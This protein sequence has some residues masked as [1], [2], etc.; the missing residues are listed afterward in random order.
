MKSQLTAIRFHYTDVRFSFS[1][2]TAAKENIVQL[3]Q[4]E[5]KSIEHINYIFCSDAYLLELNKGYLK[6]NTLTDIIT[7]H[8]HAE[9]APVHSD[10]YIS[11]ERVKE[12]A[13]SFGVSFRHELHRV[14]FHGALHLCG[15]KDKTKK[16]I[17]QMRAKEEHYLSLFHVSRGTNKRH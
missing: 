10:I 17:S 8:Y 14:L 5:G 15:Y 1:G 11:I 2:R 7:F 6:H 13:Q 12:N 16:D 4:S 9:G 3:I